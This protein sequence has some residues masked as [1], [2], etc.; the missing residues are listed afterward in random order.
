MSEQASQTLYRFASLRSPQLTDENGKSERFILQPESQ[1]TGAF[2]DEISAK[3]SKESMNSTLQLAASSFTPIIDKAEIKALRRRLYDFGL[4]LSRNR[5]DYEDNIIEQLNVE[6]VSPLASERSKTI[7][8]NL[9]Y[10]IV[11][12]QNAYLKEDLIL[13]LVADHVVSGY[14]ILVDEGKTDTEIIPLLKT[15]IDAKVVLPKELF[16]FSDEVK[17]TSVR[18]NGIVSK[19]NTKWTREQNAKIAKDKLAKI[20]VAKADIKNLKKKHQALEVANYEARLAEYKRDIQPTIDT[21]KADISKEEKAWFEGKTSLGDIQK[22]GF[23]FDKVNTTAYP[24]IPEFSYTPLVEISETKALAEMQTDTYTLLS[25]LTSISEIST[26]DEFKEILTSEEVRANRQLFE[27]TPLKQKQVSLGGTIISENP[28]LEYET[29]QEIVD[30]CYTLKFIGTKDSPVKGSCPWTYHFIISSSTKDTTINS[31]TATLKTSNT[32]GAD[33][34]TTTEFISLFNNDLYKLKFTTNNFPNSITTTYVSLTVNL[35]NGDQISQDFEANGDWLYSHI[36]CDNVADN[37]QEEDN[38]DEATSIDGLYIPT[39]YGMRQLG[40][41]DYRKVE[42]SVHCYVEGE[43]SHIENVMAR[44]YKEKETRRLRTQEDTTSISS[45][46]ETEKLT[47]STTTNRYEMQTEIAQI[48]SETKDTS[49]HSNVGYKGKAF[50]VSA[51]ANFA[52]NTSKE[53]SINQAVTEA[54]ELTAQ[55]TDRVVQKVKEERVTKIVE[56]YEETNKHGF[57]NRKGADH[58]VGVYRWVDKIYKNQIYNYGK[59]LTYE[60]LIPQPSKLHRLAMSEI[61][62]ED[63]TI[64]L[65]KPIDPRTNG[66]PDASHITETNYK[67]LGAAYNIELTVPPTEFIKIGKALSFTAM[68]TSGNEWDEIAAGAE[69]ITIPEGYKSSQ[70]KVIWHVADEPNGSHGGTQV[71][72]GGKNFTQ[73]LLPAFHNIDNFVGSIPVS[74]DSLGHHTGNIN[75]TVRCERTTD[76]YEQWQLDTFNSII[77][78]YEDL[79]ANYLAEKKAAEETAKTIYESNPLFYRQI[80]QTVLRKNCISYLVD[81]TPDATYTYGKTMYSG[82]NMQNYEVGVSKNL[83]K[84]ASFAAFMEQAFEW[85]IMSYKFYPFYWGSREDWKELYHY[86]NDDELFSNFMKSGLARVV[87]TVRPG[88]EDAVLHYMATGNIWNGGELPVIEDDLYLSVVDELKETKGLPEGKAWKTRVPTSLTI[89]QA[90]SIGLQVDKALPCNCDD[91]D[92]FEVADQTACTTE[93]VN[94][95]EVFTNLE[96]DTTTTT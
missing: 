32:S 85:D 7:W 45:E 27:N 30:V 12:Q 49:A 65:E 15:Y 72:V 31:V 6:D 80:E 95:T 11:T 93:I 17:T 10:Q 76:S 21:F 33:T 67:E 86:E 89:L 1:K 71:S 90:D 82:S 88:F 59:R 26:Y 62:A 81:Q 58:V 46:A 63:N 28:D 47:D 70:V 77:T 94:K 8:S 60:F 36:F 14:I 37:T 66:Y 57:D 91:I 64:T 78:A 41:A 34:Y 50:N 48:I 84:Y 20:A 19:L 54:Q 18:T 69:D 35:A 9:F 22:E 25:E 92:D 4:W 23:L 53:D 2:Y 51:G 61:A 13:L 68:E 5:T 24:S 42:Q 40:I 56:E 29:P 83:N 73:S 43:V 79:L 96:P 87:L 39:G 55:A 3:L 74:Y 44:A 38:T 16:N 52:Y 75:V